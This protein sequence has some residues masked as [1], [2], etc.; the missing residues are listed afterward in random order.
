MLRL[1]R[2]ALVTRILGPS[3]KSTWL[4]ATLHPG[5]R[6]LV[7]W[8]L[9]KVTEPLPPFFVQ[10]LVW[11]TVSLVVHGWN[12]LHQIYSTILICKPDTCQDFPLMSSLHGCRYPFPGGLRPP[13]GFPFEEFF[14]FS[15]R[16]RFQNKR[17]KMSALISTCVFIV[18]ETTCAFVHCPLAFHTLRPLN[19]D[20]CPF[21]VLHQ[22]S[23]LVSF[24]AS[25]FRV[26]IFGSPHGRQ[27]LVARL[28]IMLFNIL[29]VWIRLTHA[30]LIQAFQNIVQKY[31]MD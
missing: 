12:T 5:I 6:D 8:N 3:V 13:R 4:S 15:F 7:A 25:E 10:L 30:Q 28:G 17:R 14:P 29:F 20:W 18:A 22:C 31:L 16:L 24:R 19:A 27:F 2:C 21:A 9:N 23:C 1:P 26:L 11:L